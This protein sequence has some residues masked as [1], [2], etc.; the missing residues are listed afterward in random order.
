MRRSRFTWAPVL[1]FCFAVTLGYVC[2]AIGWV[3]PGALPG[4]WIAWA[5]VSAGCFLTSLI[6]QRSLYRQQTQEVPLRDR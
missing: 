6:R 3:A 1:P 2:L 4:I 5:A